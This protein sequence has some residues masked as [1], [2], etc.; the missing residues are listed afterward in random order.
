MHRSSSVEQ[1]QAETL[2]LEALNRD[3]GTSLT[4]QTI[5]VGEGALVSLDGFDEKRR[6]VCEAYA[7]V[8]KL[9]GSQPDK[10][11]SDILKMILLERTLGFSL[12]KILA[13][14][15]NAAASKVR[16]SSWLAQCTQLFGVEVKVV[17]IPEEAKES[18]RGAQRRQRMQ[19]ADS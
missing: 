2:I 12:R 3:L 10:L 7:R 4:P 14:C 19:N 15:D 17:S 16:G 9:K 6:V 5:P 1:A 11:A 8:G 18:V 13:F